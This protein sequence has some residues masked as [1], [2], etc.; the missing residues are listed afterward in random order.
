LRP[1]TPDEGVERQVRPG[2][3]ADELSPH[4]KANALDAGLVNMKCPSRRPSSLKI[5]QAIQHAK[6]LDKG[7][8]LRDAF[9]VAYWEEGRDIGQMGV[10]QEI[11]ES[12]GIDW[13]PVEAG[14]N[15]NLYLD[16]VMEDYQEGHDNGFDGIPAFIIGDVKFTGAQPMELFR[17]LADRTQQMI[18]RDPEAFTRFKRL[19]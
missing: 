2:E 9:Y 7:I 6:G 18:E 1:D 4:L 16:T 10:M 17:K 14:L 3:S 13:P 19:L 15:D 11:V 8:E 5:L 12:V